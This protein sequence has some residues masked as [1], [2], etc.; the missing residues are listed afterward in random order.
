MA[1]ATSP[2]LSIV[3]PSYQQGDFIEETLRS[4]LEDQ[5]G[6]APGDYE[7]IVMDGGSDDG[8]VDRLRARDDDPRLSWTSAPDQGQSDAINR[9]LARARGQVFNW[10]NSDD[11]LEPGAAAAVIQRF[12]REPGL[13]VL[14]GRCAKF[15]HHTREVTG[16]LQMETKRELEATMLIGRCTQPSTFWRTSIV[17]EMDG[18]HPQLRC[19]MDWHL[20]L[21][22]LVKYGMSG[23]AFTQDSLA[24]FREHPAAKSTAEGERFREEVHAIWLDLATHL[25]APAELLAFLRSL[26]PLRLDPP[27]RWEPGSHLRP[28]RLW[29]TLGVRWAHKFRKTGREEEARFLID[30]AWKCER[31]LTPMYLNSRWKLRDIAPWQPG[32]KDS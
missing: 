26:T 18:V 17:R 31:R 2:Y 15:D 9:G 29:H 7:I 8:T 3:T 1:E 20:W 24:R 25:N 28:E 32:A 30:L 21:K 10:I 22:F 13:R 27:T 19:A 12:R 23:V 6:A 4:L 11:L 16:W 5:D 14:C